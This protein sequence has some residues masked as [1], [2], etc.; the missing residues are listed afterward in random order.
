MLLAFQDVS[1]AFLNLGRTLTQLA[2]HVFPIFIGLVLTD[3]ATTVIIIRSK[4]ILILISLA[5]VILVLAANTF[6]VR[7]L[8]IVVKRLVTLVLRTIV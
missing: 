6:I 4:I 8:V 2:L 7:V 1:H 3:Y 5:Q